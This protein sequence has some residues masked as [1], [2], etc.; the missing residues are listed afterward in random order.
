MTGYT[1]IETNDDVTAATGKII[2]VVEFDAA[3]KAIKVGSAQ[4]VAKA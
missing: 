1:A 3:G 4:V 2:T